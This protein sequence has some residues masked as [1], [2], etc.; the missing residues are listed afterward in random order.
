MLYTTI[1]IGGIDYKARLTAKACVDLEKKLGTNP[2]N[3]FSQI[4]TDGSIPPLGT[5]ILILQA[6]LVTYDNVGHSVITD[7]PD[8][9]MEDV[10]KFID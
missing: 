4:A 1:T 5:L 2:L 8:Q 6:S 3:V 7:I 10:Y 9:L